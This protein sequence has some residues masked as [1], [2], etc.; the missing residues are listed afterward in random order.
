MR[1]ANLVLRFLLELGALGAAGYWG[2]TVPGGRP[3]KT[4]L[5]IGAPVAVALVWGVFISPKALIPTGRYG[6]AI[7]GF[8]VFSLAALALAARDRTPIAVVYWAV[9][10]VSSV[11]LLLWPQ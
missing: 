4:A 5:A 10:F 11:L 3:I 6:R 1:I 2:A 9:A 8:V 7:L